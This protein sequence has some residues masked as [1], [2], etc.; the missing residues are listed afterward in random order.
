MIRKSYLLQSL[1]SNEARKWA[2]HVYSVY[3]LVHVIY[4]LL[5]SLSILLG[6]LQW[7]KNKHKKSKIPLITYFQRY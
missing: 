6:I 5:I 1:L 4:V 7:N 3:F 2:E